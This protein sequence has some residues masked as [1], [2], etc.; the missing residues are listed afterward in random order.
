MNI[1]TR[2]K[3]IYQSAIVID[4]QLG[5][6]PAMPTSFEDKWKL[7]DRYAAAGVTAVTIT[8]AND[9]STLEQTIEY[10]ARIRKH[11]FANSDKYVLATKAEDIV[12]AKHSNRIALRL[13]FQGTAPM[14]KN[15]DLVEVFHQL[16]ISSMIL[17]YNIRT[18]MGDGVIEENDSGL[19]L[20]GKRLV[21][22]MNR[23]GMIIDGAHSSFK[24]IMGAAEMSIAPV[25]ISHSA[26]DALYHHKRNVTDEQIKAVAKTGGV[27]GINGL[28]LLLGD[29]NAGVGKYVDHIEY[30]LKLVG[31]KHVA[32]GLDNLYFADRFGEFMAHQTSTHPQA[33]AAIAADAIQWKFLV[34]EQLIE[35]VEVLLE[36]GY[37]EDVIKWDSWGEYLEV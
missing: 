21:A 5:F 22:E 27:I 34:P 18:P 28:G 12:E 29:A 7:I 11:I 1:S 6:E 26:I 33:Y 37:G 16:G 2:A 4:G 36:R 20:L 17:A 24:T 14:G 19:S 9:E 32:I 8:L 30:V 3:E 35:V 10:I 23:V 25:V 31:E 13:M 15:L